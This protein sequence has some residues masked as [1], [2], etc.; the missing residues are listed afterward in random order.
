MFVMLRIAKDRLTSSSL[1]KTSKMTFYVDPKYS[2]DN[3]M[4]IAIYTHNNIPASLIDSECVTFN[5]REQQIVDVKQKKTS[6]IL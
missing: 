4:P 5:V 2:I 6:T 1:Y 3:D